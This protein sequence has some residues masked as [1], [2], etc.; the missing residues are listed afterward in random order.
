MF[1]GSKTVETIRDG[2]NKRN[3]RKD[4]GKKES[5]E[6]MRNERKTCGETG[7]ESV[8]V[9]KE[10]G[11]GRK[12]SKGGREGGRMA[13]THAFGNRPRRWK[14]RRENRKDEV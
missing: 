1:L 8:K 3:R 13:G 6:E 7:T 11:E 10:K 4:G 12:G 5:V 9:V 2:N 14:T